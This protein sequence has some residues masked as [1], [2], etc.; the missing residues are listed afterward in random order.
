MSIINKGTSFANGEQLTADKINDL[1]DLATFNQ[2]ATDSQ[3]TDVNSAGQIV[4]NQG[5]IDTAQ[6][7]TDAVETAKIKNANV[8]FAKLAD[9]LDEDDMSSDSATSL[10][11]QQSIKAYVTAMRPKFVSLTGGTTDLTKTNP[12]N[13]STAVYNIAD[14]TSGDSDFATTKITGLIVQGLVACRTN[15][16]LIQAS[17]PGGSSTVI[18]RAVDTGDNG[19]SDAA[20]AFIPINSDTTS[21][22][23]TYTVNNTTFSTHCESI[24][25][26]A[27]IHPGL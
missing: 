27:I 20:T 9:V 6:L 26:G 18:C 4:V 23:L 17:L 5:G 24:I 21:F 15:T 10:A 25:K 7:A 12:S 13:G 8:T 22:T 19:I 11:T 2:D 14:F 3:T 16:N 1:I